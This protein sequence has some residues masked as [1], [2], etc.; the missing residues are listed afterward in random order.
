MTF[1]YSADSMY[2]QADSGDY[3]HLYY[4]AEDGKHFPQGSQLS[5]LPWSEWTCTF[6]WPVQGCWPKTYTSPEGGAKN[7]KPLPPNPDSEPSAVHR[8]PN[9][10]LLAVGAKGGRLKLYNYP[11]I[12]KDVRGVDQ[13][14]GAQRKDATNLL[15]FN[16]SHIG[17]SARGRWTLQGRHSSSLLF[18]REIPHFGWQTRQ[19]DYC[20]ESRGLKGADIGSDTRNNGRKGFFIIRKK[21]TIEMLFLPIYYTES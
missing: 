3:E 16:I 4:E 21:T 5:D 9:E 20:V 8:S 7:K 11:C 12:S 1:D 2:V 18:R 17:G 10:K 13:C 19:G 6:G 14:H 15:A